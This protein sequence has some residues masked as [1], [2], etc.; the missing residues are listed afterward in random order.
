MDNS[1][2]LILLFDARNDK[3]YFGDSI[4]DVVRATGRIGIDFHAR[5]A[6]IDD[7]NDTVSFSSDY[8]RDELIQQ[9]FARGLRLL[10]RDH[11]F[12]LFTSKE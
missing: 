5:G 1:K 7:R 3:Y 10:C 6:T 8:S 2:P 9:V 12:I 4:I 11:G